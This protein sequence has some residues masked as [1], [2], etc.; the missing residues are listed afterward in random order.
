[1]DT[2]LGGPQSHSGRLGEE[3]NVL[4]L[5]AMEPRFIITCPTRSLVDVPTALSRQGVTSF[6]MSCMAH[7]EKILIC[8]YDPSS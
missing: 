5:Q 4:I 7:T 1:M 2:R 8:L 6:R 3:N